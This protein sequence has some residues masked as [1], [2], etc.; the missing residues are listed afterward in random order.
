MEHKACLEALFRGLCT[1]LPFLLKVLRMVKYERFKCTL[2]H[3]SVSSSPERQPVLS[4][5]VMNACRCGLCLVACSRR[6]H[7]DWSR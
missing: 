2:S 4:A 6:L 1:V 5:S 3:V 7:S